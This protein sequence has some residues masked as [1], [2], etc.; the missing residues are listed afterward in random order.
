[1]QVI[2]VMITLYSKV[3]SFVMLVIQ[4]ALRHCSKAGNTGS[5]SSVN[6]I[7]SVGS[8]SNS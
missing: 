5:C 2:L 4:V 1:M 6:G 3:G 8:V 7:S